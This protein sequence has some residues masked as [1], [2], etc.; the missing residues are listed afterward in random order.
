MLEWSLSCWEVCLPWCLPFLCSEWNYHRVLLF[1]RSVLL[2]NSRRRIYS[3]LQDI[4]FFHSGVAFIYK[5]ISWHEQWSETEGRREEEEEE[6]EE[7]DVLRFMKMYISLYWVCKWHKIHLFDWCFLAQDVNL[8]RL[9]LSLSKGKKE[10]E[11][12]KQNM[13]RCNKVLT[14]ED[15][16]TTQE[17][18]QREKKTRIYRTE[19]T[20]LSVAIDWLF[21]KSV[22]S[23]SLCECDLSR[24]NWCVFANC[25]QINNWWCIT[26]YCMTVICINY[27]WP[28]VTRVTC[29]FAFPR[30]LICNQ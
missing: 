30:P 14:H 12:A 2:L 3:T 9:H 7:E 21:Y 29:V 20:I 22:L 15:T 25:V 4:F 11:K 13:N 8:H 17:Q 28:S 24:F 10:K 6:E 26:I 19:W 5:K 27:S 1:L 18:K 16:H 23:L